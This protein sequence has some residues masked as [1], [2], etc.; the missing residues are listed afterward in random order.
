MVSAGLFR[1]TNDERSTAQAN[2][3]GLRNLNDGFNDSLANGTRNSQS[4]DLVGMIVATPNDPNICGIVNSIGGGASNGF[5][6]VKFSCTDF[7][8]GGRPFGTVGFSDND[9]VH[10]ERA[11]TI[12]SF[13]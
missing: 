11:S 4:A 6:V 9:R 12:A 8:V 5:F 1:A 7:T 2:A 3:S 10:R 13:R